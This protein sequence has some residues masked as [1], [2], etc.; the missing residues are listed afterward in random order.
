MCRETCWYRDHEPTGD[1]KPPKP[2]IPL[3]QC[4]H[5]GPVLEYCT[6]CG[7]V[8]DVHRCDHFDAEVILNPH[9]KAKPG[10][11]NCKECG[12]NPANA[13]KAK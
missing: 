4:E 7:G 5:L 11:R 9:K 13:E 10:V 1:E 8:G 2:R 6:T 12:E 3:P